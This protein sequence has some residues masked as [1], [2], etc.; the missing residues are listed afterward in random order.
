[1]TI[2]YNCNTV[3]VKFYTE[4]TNGWVEK[5]C[6]VRLKDIVTFM[7]TI[8]RWSESYTHHSSLEACE[9]AIRGIRFFFLNC[10]LIWQNSVICD[11]GLFTPLITNLNRASK[12]FVCQL[13]FLEPGRSKRW[14]RTSGMEITRFLITTVRSRYF[15]HFPKWPR[16]FLWINLTTFWLNKATSPATWARIA[17]NTLPTPWICLLPLKAIDKKEITPMVLCHRTLLLT[18][19]RAWCVK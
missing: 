6:G 19:A 17:N 5:Q 15:P 13:H 2:A 8:Y 12:P 9:G 4:T 10:P 1:M 3:H 14:C 18:V 7:A 11:Q 16:R